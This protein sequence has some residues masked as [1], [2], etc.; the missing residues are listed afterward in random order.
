M[1]SNM[2]SDDVQCGERHKV[3][4]KMGSK[5]VDLPEARNCQFIK[6]AGSVM[7][8]PGDHQGNFSPIRLSATYLFREFTIHH[9]LHPCQFI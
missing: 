7:Q 8:A 9:T 6:G 3:E 2:P 5:R 1:E 4:R